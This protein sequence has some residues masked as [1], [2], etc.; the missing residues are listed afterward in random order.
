M[1]GD[2]AATYSPVGVSTNHERGGRGGS[3]AQWP[4]PGGPSR[5][6]PRGRLP[7]CPGR[8]D[9]LGVLWPGSLMARSHG[10][11]HE[12]PQ[13][14]RLLP[15]GQDGRVILLVGPSEQQHDRQE[16]LG[17]PA[18]ARHGLGSALVATVPRHR[19]P[20]A[21]KERGHRTVHHAFLRGSVSIRPD[22]RGLGRVRLLLPEPVPAVRERAASGQGTLQAATVPPLAEVLRPAVH[23]ARITEA[24]RPAAGTDQRRETTVQQSQHRD[25]AGL[26]AERVGGQ[27]PGF[28]PSLCRRA[29]FVRLGGAGLAAVPAKRP[30][31]R[32]V[33]GRRRARFAAA[34]AATTAGAAAL[35]ATAAAAAADAR[36]RHRL[37]EDHGPLPT[38]L[39]TGSVRERSVR[40]VGRQRRY[41]V[42]PAIV[43]RGFGVRGGG[44]VDEPHRGGLLRER[45]LHVPRSA[46]A[47]HGA[48]AHAPRLDRHAA[49]QAA[50][51]IRLA[52]AVVILAMRA[53]GTA[54]HERR[55]EQ[56]V[57]VRYLPSVRRRTVR[58]PAANYANGESSRCWSRGR[59]ATP[60]GR[61]RRSGH[62]RKA[63][64]GRCSTEA[65]LEQDRLHPVRLPGLSGRRPR[66]ARPVVAAVDRCAPDISAPATAPRPASHH[67]PQ[68]D[69]PAGPRHHVRAALRVPDPHGLRARGVR[70]CGPAAGAVLRLHGPL[71]GGRLVLKDNADCGKTYTGFMEPRP[72][73]AG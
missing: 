13:H 26:A 20:D 6:L 2:P 64:S 48:V 43:F 65:H 32:R 9:A 71:Q 7:V 66:E 1:S 30:R 51:G 24:P 34:A 37:I 68:E 54:A 45:G 4:T 55:E 28:E 50:A 8:C 5:G 69:M 53:R 44:R 56:P 58:P 25:D 46:V 29:R 61:L 35:R 39:R 21:N 57:P 72:A 23:G 16:A 62:H 11:L 22:K 40:R 36:L 15:H 19:H 27:A 63:S 60:Y 31:R 10:G 12:A 18:T 67:L 42:S 59:T 3:G 47:H 38:F 73:W 17:Q 49:R 33:R 41:D 52:T 14:A 70:A